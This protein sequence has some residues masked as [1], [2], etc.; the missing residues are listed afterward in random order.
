MYYFIVEVDYMKY[1]S[2]PKFKNFPKHRS[3]KLKL[4][5]NAFTSFEYR[6]FAKSDELN[7]TAFV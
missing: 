4:S 3:A 7:I 2:K 5:I 1:S 6:Y